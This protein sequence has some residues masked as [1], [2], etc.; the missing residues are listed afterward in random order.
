M[1][2]GVLFMGCSSHSISK[3]A[4]AGMSIENGDVSVFTGGR[5]AGKIETSPFFGLV[6]V[7][8]AKR[9]DPYVPSLR[10]WPMN[11]LENTHPLEALNPQ[12]RARF[13]MID[14]GALGH[15][16]IYLNTGAGSLIVDTA[17]RPPPPRAG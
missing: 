13:P 11:D 14:R 16:R 8:W 3:S 9:S 1:M 12:I 5:L 17:A 10:K 4:A 6:L 15:P 7:E 2:A